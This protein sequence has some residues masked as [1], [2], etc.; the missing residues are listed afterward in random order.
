VLAV[1]R[2]AGRDSSQGCRTT[3]LTPASML[4]CCCAAELRKP[5]LPAAH[6]QAREVLR[7]QHAAVYAG[8]QRPGQLAAAVAA[9]HV[10][11]DVVQRHQHL[12]SAGAS[13]R[14][15]TC[16]PLSCWAGLGWAGLAAA[17]V[18]SCWHSQGTRRRLP[19]C[20]LRMQ[21]ESSLVP[22]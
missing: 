10:A 20:D 17:A 1:G 13:S 9:A 21:T 3:L 6:L 22:K 15:W 8:V 2:A 7:R 19:T 12:H 14:G 5:A 16:A 11:V 18:A 4:S